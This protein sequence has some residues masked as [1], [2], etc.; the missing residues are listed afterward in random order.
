MRAS[1]SDEGSGGRSASV[2]EH[3]RARRVESLALAA[4]IA[5]ILVLPV[6]G[7]KAV[8]GGIYARGTVTAAVLAMHAIGIVLVHRSDRF[9][10]VAQVQVGALGG[11]LFAVLVQGDV[12]FRA[13]DT[14]CPPCMDEPGRA[15]VWTGYV[16]SV[17]LGL[18]LSVA[19]SLTLYVLVVR[20]LATSSR[21]VLTVASIFAVQALAGFRDPL[22]NALVTEDQAAR[23]VPTGATPPPADLTLPLG[24]ANFTGPDLLLVVVAVLSMVG[25]AAY[26]RFTSTGTAIRAAAASRDRAETLGINVNAV[27]SR[28]WVLVGL[29]SGTAATIAVMGSGEETLSQGLNVSLLVRILAVVV[30]ARLTSL[31]MV[32]VAALTFGVLDQVVLWVFGSTLP[33][34]GALLFIV[35]GLLLAQRRERS[36]ADEDRTWQAARELRPIPGVL[37][38]LPEVRR[39]VRVGTTTLVVVLAALPWVMSP[40]QTNRITVAL[41]YAMVGLSLLVLT[42]WAGLVSLGQFAFAAVGGWVAAVSGLPILLALPVGAA[43]GAAVALLVGLPA[44]K[45]RGLYLAIT[46]LALSLSVSAVLLNARYLGA[47]LPDELDRPSFVGLDLD[48]QRVSF[49]VVL[50]LLVLTALAV[51]GLRRSRT[52]RILIAARDNEAAVASIG[53]SLTRLRLQV[54]ALSGGIAALAGVMFSYQQGGVQPD[55]FSPELSVDIFVFTVIGGFGS[56]A[57]PLLGFTY[58]ALVSLLSSDP[59]VV[60]LASGL[61]G[62]ALTLAAP[63]G[64]VQIAFR[65]RDAMLR[66]VARRRRIRVTG[67]VADHRDDDL[68]RRAEVRPKLGAGG[69]PAFVPRRYGLDGQWLI[70]PERDGRDRPAGR[71]DDRVAR[72]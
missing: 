60:Q 7:D 57:G 23:G 72:V 38:D 69:H 29:L 15:A 14:V 5:G 53:V 46:T 65:L 43:A 62:L 54:F 32:G 25:L 18:L 56:L 68:D 20:R 13:L 34:D 28:V 45:L 41:I 37:R 67:L 55:A 66:R 26:L 22:V 64:L 48:D 12:L 36:R 47:L 9:L 31:P 6:I 30:V 11:S 61:G 19:I 58:F 59:T 16:V 4:V 39:Y 44:L 71:E 24:G 21:L 50:V 63:G 27:T 35:G 8:P 10:N 40:S 1:G 52:G 2:R 70:D 42:G 51:V 3:L 33:V 17:G 49:Y